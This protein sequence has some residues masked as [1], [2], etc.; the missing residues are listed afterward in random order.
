LLS[1]V[2][3]KS[4]GVA[5]FG[6][7]PFLFLLQFFWGT[8]LGD[9]LWLYLLQEFVKVYFPLILFATFV[10]NSRKK[11]HSFLLHWSIKTLVPVVNVCSLVLSLSLISFLLL[12]SNIWSWRW[13]LSSKVIFEMYIKKISSWFYSVSCLDWGSSLGWTSW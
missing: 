10:R 3:H 2:A 9:N 1:H 6:N 8:S 13:T 7:H 11:L 12:Q 4:G 5:N